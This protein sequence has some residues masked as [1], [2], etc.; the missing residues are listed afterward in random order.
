MNERVNRER[1]RER[2]TKVFSKLSGFLHF[3]IVDS[4]HD[5]VENIRKVRKRLRIM[6]SSLLHLREECYN[7]E[8]NIM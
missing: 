3:T 7:Y 1:E 2:E 4:S 8:R 5:Q 6:F